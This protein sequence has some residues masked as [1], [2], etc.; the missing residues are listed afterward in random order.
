MLT[1]KCGYDITAERKFPGQS[2]RPHDWRPESVRQQCEDS[3]RRLGTDRIDLYQLHNPRIEPILAD[4][5]WATLIDLKAEGKVRELGVAL[6]PAIGWV[7]EGVRCDRRPPDRDAADRVQRARAGAGADLRAATARR[8]HGEVSLISR[9]P[10]ASDTLSGRVDARHRV[11]PEGPPRRTATATTCSTT[12]RRPRRCRSCGH[13]DRPHDRAGRDRRRSSPTPRSRACC[14]RVLTVDDV[15]EYA[16][17]ADFP[18]TDDEQR[19]GRGAVVAQ[20]RPRRSLRDAAQVERLTRRPYPRCDFLPTNVASSSSRSRA[21]CSR[22]RASTT[23]SMD[24]IAEARRRH[25]A[26]ALPALPEQ[27]GRSTSSCSTDTGDQLL[28]QLARPRAAARSGRERVEAGF[29][30][31]FRFVVRRPRRRSGCCSAR[32]SAPIPSSPASS[33][34]SCRPPPTSSP[35]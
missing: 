3:L 2:E 1:T 28:D 35:S 4:D 30:A 9:V 16:A 7:E 12:S 22:E 26:G 10:H 17:A 13:G 32:R 15:R 31:Y 25:Q 8:Q 34:R 29:L 6:G 23:T 33:T 24:D 11:R 20:L 27:D 18:L 5:L 14:R 21:T 19:R